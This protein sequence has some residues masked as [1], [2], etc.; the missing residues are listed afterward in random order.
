M[1]IVT[2]DTNTRIERS[3]VRSAKPKESANLREDPLSDD[4][5]VIQSILK[6]KPHPDVIDQGV[7]SHRYPTRN[8][9]TTTHTSEMNPTVP[10]PGQGKNHQ[11]ELRSM[12]A[13]FEFQDFHFE[14]TECCCSRFGFPPQVCGR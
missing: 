13:E 7:S 11:Y 8:R 14:K 9:T 4:D 5:T 12:N 2:D 1:I 6:Q 10:V 3:V